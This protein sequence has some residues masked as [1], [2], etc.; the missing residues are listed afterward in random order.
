M[1]N[2]GDKPK[3]G[4]EYEVSIDSI[5]KTGDGVAWINGFVVFVKEAIKGQKYNIRITK[6]MGSYGFAEIIE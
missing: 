3:I 6:L 5:G 2:N 4:E 1:N